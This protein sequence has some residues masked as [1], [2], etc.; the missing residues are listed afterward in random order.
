V[1]LPKVFDVIIIGGGPA[2][3]A[4][5]ITLARNGF[6]TAIIERSNYSTIRVGETLPAAIRDLLIKLD[7]WESFLADGHRESFALRSVWG[8]DQQ[9]ESNSIFNPYGPGWHINRGLFDAML[10][11]KAASE[12]SIVFTE[13]RITRLSKDQTMRWHVDVLQNNVHN[14]MSAMFIIDATG[15]TAVIPI[16]LPRTFRVV[17]H[18][19]GVA[20]F[21]SCIADPYI[22]VE[23]I[24]SGWWY[25][26]PLPQGCL[27]AAYMTDADLLAA[28]NTSP[29][30]HWCLQLRKAN[31]TC[32]RIGSQMTVTKSKI[33]SAASVIRRPV[34]GRNWLATGDASI[35]FD[36][37]SGRGV[38]SALQGGILAGEAVMAKFCGNKESFSE[39]TFWINNQFSNYLQ[40]RTAFYRREQRWSQNPFWRRRHSNTNR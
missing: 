38:Y 15:Q 37:L 12:G 8:N 27:V 23:A 20:R 36:P 22:L 40:N 18:L 19:I 13:A 6:R 1:T 24:D 11:R 26:A 17:D 21:L 14:Y 31:L 2:G 16:G 9:L 29:Y 5:A 39:Y 30:D 3:T 32:M 10:S 35:T 34:C 28:S 33:V 7:V 25:S 4:A